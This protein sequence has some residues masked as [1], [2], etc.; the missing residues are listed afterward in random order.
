MIAK[1]W[2]PAPQNLRFTYAELGAAVDELA[3]GLIAAGL[4]A[5]DRLGIWSPNAAEW[6]LVQYATAKLGVILVNINPAYQTSELEYVLRQSGLP[7]ADLCTGVQDLGLS[8][9]DR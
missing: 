4:H 6:T 1:L 7:D 8:G 9:H 5:G 3:R 2:S